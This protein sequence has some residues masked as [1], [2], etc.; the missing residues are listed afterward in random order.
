VFAVSCRTGEFELVGIFHA[1]YSGASALNVVV[2][3]DQVREM[4]SSLKRTTRVAVPEPDGAARARLADAARRG[5]DLPFFP[6]GPHV[7]S[8]RVR[9]DGAFVFAMFSSDFP[10]TSSPLL[11]IEDL[12]SDD[13]KSFGKVGGVYLGGPLGLQQLPPTEADAETQG[14]LVHALGAL[15]EGALATFD[16]RNASRKTAESRAA[17]ERTTAKKRTLA[18]LLQVQRDTAQALVELV[19]RAAAKSSGPVLELTDLETAPGVAALAPSG[20]AEHD[21]VQAATRSP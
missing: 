19:G 7:A 11:V 13:P 16:W 18:R 14:L 9:P 10:R 12:P 21:P 20:G 15:R 1:H 17:F 5:P 8:V 2:A 6:F 3:I 4:M